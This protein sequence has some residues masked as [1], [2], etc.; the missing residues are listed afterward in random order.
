MMMMS[1]VVVMM[2]TM[3]TRMILNK[4]TNFPMYLIS[5]SLSPQNCYIILFFLKNVKQKCRKSSQRQLKIEV[6][7]SFRQ[8]Q[9]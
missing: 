2:K 5:V 4:T 7:E 6:K 3:T 1:V 8:S 9:G